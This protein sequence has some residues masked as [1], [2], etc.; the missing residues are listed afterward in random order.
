MSFRKDTSAVSELLQAEVALDDSEPVEKPEHPCPRCNA[1]LVNPEALGWCPKCGYCR[2]LEDTKALAPL[3]VA[4]TVQQPSF[5]GMREFWDLVGKLPTWFWILVNG[6]AAI[7]LL[8]LAAGFA[9]RSLGLAL[10]LWSTI[11]LGVGILGFFAVQIWALILLTPEDDTLGPRALVMSSRLW[12]QVLKRLPDTRWQLWLG[13][14]CLTGVVS[15]VCLSGGLS[16]WYQFYKP[17]RY[18]ETNLLA[19]AAQMMAHGADSDKNLEEAVEAFAATQN[20][21]KKKD[22]NKDPDVFEA[23]YRPTVQC[24]VIGYR[25]SKDQKL[26]ALLMATLQYGQLTYSGQVDRGW[27]SSSAG[28]MLRLLKPLVTDKPTFSNLSAIDAIWVQPKV[29]CEVHSSGFDDKGR[30]RKPNYHGLL[31]QQ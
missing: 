31:Q 5:M 4:A 8:S 26:E 18:A 28:E 15:A 19:A 27:N 25:L 11:Q 7:M 10:A 3:K 1:K 20:L 29:F 30:L 9:L 6:M 24:V 17:K 2:S 16:Y 13:S 21:T 14:W 22:E 12:S 23:D